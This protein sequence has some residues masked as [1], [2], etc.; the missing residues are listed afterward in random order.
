MTRPAKI[1]KEALVLSVAILGA[2]A[3]LRAPVAHAE[4]PAPIKVAVVDIQRAAFETEDG[5]RAQA[6]LKKYSE[7]RNL[8]LGMRQDDLERKR[9]DIEKQSKVMS[10]E[11]LARALEDWQK[12]AG[13]LQAVYM[14]Y[15]RDMQK[16][17]QDVA[18]PILGKLSGLVRKI[19]LRDN[20]DVVFDRQATPYAR[21]ELDIT[22]QIIVMY[23]AGE[24]GPAEPAKSGAPATSGAPPAAP[25]PPASSSAAP[26]PKK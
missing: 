23:N 4:G 18:A 6:T 13:E 2:A 17:Q 7:R 20:L 15:S 25:A 11:S 21:P 12:Q 22:D 3:I 26:S 16:K 24:A 1:R 19:S 5:L 9:A 14:D 8:E 10:K